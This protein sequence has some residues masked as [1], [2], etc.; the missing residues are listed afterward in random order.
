M[1]V[2]TAA[3][4]ETRILRTERGRVMS[5]K[6]EKTITVEV[7][8]TVK[9]PKYGKYI[10]LSTKYNAHDEKNEAKKG[11]RV[12]ICQTRPISKQ[13]RWRLLRV[14][15]RA[16]DLGGIEVKEVEVPGAKPKPKPEA[17]PE[18]KAEPKA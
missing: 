1:A 17:A 10:H 6:R 12:E 15:E 14:L 8:R 4:A 9:H 3:A 2:E 16:A 5:D 13:K 7:T 11:D 18:S